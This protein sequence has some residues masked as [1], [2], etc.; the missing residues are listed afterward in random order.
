MRWTRSIGWTG[1]RNRRP[2]PTTVCYDSLGRRAVV[3]RNER[4]G[5]DQR[6]LRAHL[7]EDGNLVVEGQDL[8]PGT[9][10]V[11]DDGEY[12][13]R[14]RIAAADIAS[15]RSVL[16]IGEDVDILDELGRNW[17]GPASYEL[18]RRIRESGIPVQFSSW[19]G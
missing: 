12:E 17:S 18:E 6:H 13:Y 3:L 15:L 8:G 9:A 10:L 19:G 5:K 2:Q 11:S 14:K 16:S 7:D 4:K 1:A